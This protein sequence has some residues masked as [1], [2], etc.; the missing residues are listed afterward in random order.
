M[1]TATRGTWPAATA[2]A[3][4]ANPLV[5]GDFEGAVARLSG[6]AAEAGANGTAAGADAG[7]DGSGDG[8]GTAAGGKAAGGGED[9]QL[10]QDLGDYGR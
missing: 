9:P 7:D 6:G 4:L 3:A 10:Y 2:D 1:D 8:K 5:F